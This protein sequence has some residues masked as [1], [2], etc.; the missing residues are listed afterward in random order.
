VKGRVGRIIWVSVSGHEKAGLLQSKV[1][2][3]VSDLVRMRP[4]EIEWRGPHPWAA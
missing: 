1:E 3:W 4:V 2:Q